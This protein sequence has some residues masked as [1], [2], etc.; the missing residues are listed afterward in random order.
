MASAHPAAF[1][2]LEGQVGRIAPGTAA[3]LVALNRELE[4]TRSWVDGA[5]SNR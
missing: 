1:L 3:S 2:R 4:A 5:D